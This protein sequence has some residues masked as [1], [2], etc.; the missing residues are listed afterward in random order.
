MTTQRPTP[1]PR[2]RSH[3]SHCEPRSARR[4]L[5]S[6]LAVAFIAWLLLACQSGIGPI[7][8]TSFPPDLSYIPPER[9]KA[10]MWVL[11]AEIQ[12]L[13]GLLDQPRGPSR[14]TLRLE[15]RDSLER[16][17]VA[18]MRLDQ[19]GRTS[20]HPVLDDHIGPFIDRLE[21]AKRSVDRD[22]PN[23]FPAST[24]AGSCFLCHGQ[25]QAAAIRP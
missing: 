20:Q 6:I 14:P 12:H 15:V 19:S 25:T 4:L 2:D 9:I 16:M 18:A 23:Y 22:P 10:S 7:R 3:R 8:A 5:R 17:R 1:D 11:A 21:R 24:I 13:E